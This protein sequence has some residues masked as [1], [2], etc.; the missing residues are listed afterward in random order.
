MIE[1]SRGRFEVKRPT[2]KGWDLIFKSLP[3][4]AYDR[5][6]D[7]I[8]L[9]VNAP[10]DDASE[11]ERAEAFK[12]AGRML[13]DFL[14]F[15]P[16]LAGAVM[17]ACL[18]KPDGSAPTLDEGMEFDDTDLDAVVSELQRL[19][20]IADMLKRLGNRLGRATQEVGKG[21]ASSNARI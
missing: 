18:R 4:E 6:Y 14:A 10:T 7:A 1:T 9:V 20:I 21:A 2:L 5:I 19:G 15:V 12:R 3:H 16:S 17:A 8:L 13:L 11:K